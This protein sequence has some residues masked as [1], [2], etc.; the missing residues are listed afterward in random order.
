MD[1][2]SEST[3]EDNEANFC[4]MYVS[5][6]MV[7]AIQ[8]IMKF[9]FFSCHDAKAKYCCPR[10]NILYCS[11]NCY[12]S[13]V[14]LQCSEHFY[15]DNVLNEINLN[16]GEESKTKMLQVLQKNHTNDG[17]FDGFNDVEGGNLDSDD[18][19]NCKDI[20]ERLSG[21]NLDDTDEVWEKLTEDE[22]QEFVAFLR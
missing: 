7:K 6:F 12:Q 18:D 15:K 3:V 22:R 13:N 9:I 14:H 2:G 11:L 10:C 1:E 19:D 8:V 20:A 5:S 21:V 16:S 17:L 4:K